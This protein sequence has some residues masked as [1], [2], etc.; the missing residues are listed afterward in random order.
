MINAEIKANCNWGK[1][2]THPEWTGVGRDIERESLCSVKTSA[3]FKSGPSAR[4]TFDH[5]R[6]QSL[7]FC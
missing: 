2:L 5:A 6:I 1:P 4:V 3:E 7:G